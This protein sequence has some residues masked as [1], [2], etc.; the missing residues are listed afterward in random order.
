MFVGHY[1]ASLAA[2]AIVKPAPL[3]L[4]FIAAQ[5]VDILFFPFALA[6]IETLRLLPP[7]GGG[8]VVHFELP[9][10]PYTHS[11]LAMLI[12][13]ALLGGGA[14]LAYRRRSASAAA[15]GVAVGLTVVSHWV[16]DWLVHMPDMTLW[17]NDSPHLGLGL[18]QHGLLTF[19]LEAVLLLAAGALY[20]RGTRPVVPAGRWSMPV[21]MVV[22]LVCDAVN[23]FAPVDGMGIVPVSIS[24]L[25]LYLGF[26][27]AAG[28]I[29]RQREAIARST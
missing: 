23:L 13:G 1:S 14:W 29:E 15:I 10:M 26:A 9:N 28:K 22:M 19:A 20:L 11:L 3:W 24:A 16:L 21:F 7:Q 5:W 8:S 12:W 25:A 2:K 4:L 17:G 27:T 18:W 6:G